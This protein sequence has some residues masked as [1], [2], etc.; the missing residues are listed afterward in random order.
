VSL[1]EQMAADA[2]LFT[3]VAD[4]GEEV[5]YTQKSGVQHEGFPL[6][7]QQGVT[8]VGGQLVMI[9]S[10][11]TVIFSVARMNPGSGDF[12]TR[13]S[14]DVWKIDATSR[15]DSD[16]VFWRVHVV[17]NRQGVFGRN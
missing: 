7:F 12:F 6:L 3:N 14:G 15:R 9:E 5:V 10:E 8:M 4:F 16:G 2:D 17:S 11:A 1:N 13:A